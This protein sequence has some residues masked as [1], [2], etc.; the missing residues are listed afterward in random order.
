MPLF[1]CAVYTAVLIFSFCHFHFCAI[2]LIL[3]S[4]GLC[5]PLNFSRGRLCGP[6]DK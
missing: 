4:G 6:V 5:N 3:L 1:F 2:S